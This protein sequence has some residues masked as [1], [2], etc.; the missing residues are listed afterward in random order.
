MLEYESY[1]Y[2]KRLFHWKIESSFFIF[3]L[4][5]EILAKLYNLVYY[6]ILTLTLTPQLSLNPNR[7]LHIKCA[8][9]NIAQCSFCLRNIILPVKYTPF[10]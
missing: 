1:L 5:A 8:L 6:L 3:N 2:W 4:N 7:K 9:M 10:P